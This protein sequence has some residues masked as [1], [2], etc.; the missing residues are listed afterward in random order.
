MGEFIHPCLC[1]VLDGDYAN[2]EVII[3]DDGSGDST[4]ILC[5]EFTTETGR[6]YDERVIYLSKVNGGKASALNLGLKH[7]RGQYISVLD[8]DDELPR[9]SIACR[10]EKMLEFSDQKAMVIGGFEVFDS[11]VILGKREVSIKSTKEQ[12][13]SAFHSSFKTPFH[14]NS[15]LLSK[16]LID[17]VGPFDERLFR[18][19]DIDYSIRS[20]IS[21]THVIQVNE[22]V[23]RYRKH[24]EDIFHRLRIRYKTLFHRGQVFWKN[25]ESPKRYRIVATSALLDL[26][27][28]VYEVFGNYKK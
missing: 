2:I 6:H 9:Q 18:C 17:D 1:S 12:L 7:A 14:A 15:C 11:G 23:Y 19:Q 5:E 21:A 20:L 3:I 22:I 28:L 26:L 24:R 4:N 25:F 27:K 16:K 8:A 10:L 13:L